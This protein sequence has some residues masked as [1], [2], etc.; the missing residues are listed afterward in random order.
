MIIDVCSVTVDKINV[1]VK[2]KSGLS[3]PHPVRRSV[4]SDCFIASLLAMIALLAVQS[5]IQT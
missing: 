1:A 2:R 5:S 4:N 3:L